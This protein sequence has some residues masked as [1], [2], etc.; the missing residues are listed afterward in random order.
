[1]PFNPEGGAPVDY[2]QWQLTLDR[3]NRKG[4]VLDAELREK[5][6]KSLHQLSRTAH[7]KH[8][9]EQFVDAVR[10]SIAE[11]CSLA[12]IPTNNGFC[13]AGPNYAAVNW[14][15]YMESPEQIATLALQ[16][17]VDSIAREVNWTVLVDKIGAYCETEAR[18][19]RLKTVNP[20]LFHAIKK[21]FRG[22]ALTYS[23]STKALEEYGIAVTEWGPEGRATVGAFLLDRVIEATGLVHTAWQITHNRK[24]FL[25]VVPDPLVLDFLKKIPPSSQGDPATRAIRVLP[26]S[27]WDDSN[28]R[29]YNTGSIEG[30]LIRLPGYASTQR[31]ELNLS[32]LTPEA[33]AETISAANYLQ[34]QQLHIPA[35]LAC[36]MW[37]TWDNDRLGT[38]DLF[39]CS[40]NPKELPPLL[41]RGSDESA[42]KQRNR[43]AALTHNDHRENN[44]KRI[45]IHRTLTRAKRLA[46]HTLYAPVTA[47]YRGRLYTVGEGTYQGDRLS[48]A[49]CHFQPTEPLSPDGFDWLL[50]SAAAAHQGRRLSFSDRLAWAQQNLDLIKIVGQETDC[51]VEASDASDP[52]RFIAACQA[53]TQHLDDPSSPCGLPVYFDQSCSGL[54]HIAALQR[55]HL[56]AQRTRICSGPEAALD[57]YETVAQAL[58]HQAE[59]DFHA[60]P[61]TSGGNPCNHTKARA[62]FWLTNK[63]SRGVIKEVIISTPYGITPWGIRQLITAQ[64]MRKTNSTD[65]K[66]LLR[67]VDGPALYL[68]KSFAKVLNPYIQN[69][70]E[71]KAWLKLCAS[72]IAKTNSPL[73]FTAPNGLVIRDAEL[74]TTKKQF[75]TVLNGR[76][77]AYKHI[78]PDENSKINFRSLSNRI[79]PNYIHAI[80]A[81]LCTS[82]INQFQDLALPIASIHDCF[83]TTP[84]HAAKLHS[85]LLQ[86]I[87]HLH[88][89][90]WLQSTHQEWQQAYSLELP[91]PPIVGDLD[92]ASIGSVPALFS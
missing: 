6:L 38:Q 79:V 74:T 51:P 68:T 25:K 36:L 81:S 41:P 55:D 27:P 37:R 82:V 18:A 84:N 58:T 59:L 61:L 3:Q 23:F 60:P 12:L 72:T 32:W 46:G 39:P 14:L 34:G 63:I 66:T 17:V 13:R 65:P 9:F 33:L 71:L 76:K 69:A 80:D 53:I 48:R 54:G 50:R 78:C 88:Q 5:R 7:G 42:W 91:P 29:D 56:S 43:Q 83:A 20:G 52:W 31:D 49:L 22:H 35:A 1:M 4:A 44:P 85:T 77:F 73:H 47:D 30:G 15:L 28:L 64:L 10:I 62:R 8:L 87:N 67:F 19:G 89:T 75:P 2:A 70:N 21:R 86:S 90:P 26:P 92:P 57:L 16:V 40:R 11:T 24:R 45:A